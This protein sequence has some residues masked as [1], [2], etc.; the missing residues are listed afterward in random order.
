MKIFKMMLVNTAH[1]IALCFLALIVNKNPIAADPCFF[2][3]AEFGNIVQC[4]SY[5]P[6]GTNIICNGNGTIIF[7]EYRFAP[8]PTPFSIRVLLEGGFAQDLTHSVIAAP[9]TFWMVHRSGG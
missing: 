5:I 3:D 2:I 6:P 9:R 1:K 7:E 4:R 8:T